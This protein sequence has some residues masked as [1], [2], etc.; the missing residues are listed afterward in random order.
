MAVPTVTKRYDEPIEVTD[1]PF[2]EAPPVAFRWRGR[3][4]HVDEP[5][6]QWRETSSNWDPERRRDRDYHRILARPAG[7][8]FSGDIDADGFLQR[9]N[10]ENSAVFDLYEDHV[11]GGWRIARVWD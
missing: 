1:A 7:S 8:S 9:D 10:V 3:S 2:K 11:R 6:A 5:L 4:Y